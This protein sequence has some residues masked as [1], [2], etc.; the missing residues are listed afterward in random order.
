MDYV[1]LA[2]QWVEHVVSQYGMTHV[3]RKDIHR[4]GSLLRQGYTVRAVRDPS[5]VL[6]VL[7][8]DWSRCPGSRVLRGLGR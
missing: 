6:Q 4:I 8:L 3:C 5:K 2:E 1:K 7:C